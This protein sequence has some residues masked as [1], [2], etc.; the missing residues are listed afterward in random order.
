M[1]EKGFSVR[2]S[3]PMEVKALNATITALAVIAIFISQIN[4]VW[5]MALLLCLGLIYFRIQRGRW[6]LCTEPLQIHALRYENEAWWFLDKANK[7]YLV[8]LVNAFVSRW[9]VIIN[10]QSVQLGKRSVILSKTSTD[11]VLFRQLRCLLRGHYR[12]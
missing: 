8:T 11:K 5:K 7:P 10:F 1:Y 6:P 12:P 9:L 3:E 2:I 4:I